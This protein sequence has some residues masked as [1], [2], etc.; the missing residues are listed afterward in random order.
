MDDIFT[1][2]QMTVND[3]L[4]EICPESIKNLFLFIIIW[5]LKIQ[6][7]GQMVY[8]HVGGTLCDLAD[9]LYPPSNEPVTLKNDKIIKVGKEQYINRWSCQEKCSR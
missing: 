3:K 4:V 7:I 1:K 9:S 8:I 2:Y 5:I 6:K